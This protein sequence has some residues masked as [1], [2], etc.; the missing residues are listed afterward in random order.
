M[1]L[2]KLLNSNIAITRDDSGSPDSYRYQ[3]TELAAF[4]S[5]LVKSVGQA[6]SE[7]AA[8]AVVAATGSPMTIAA[9]ARQAVHLTGGTV[10]AVALVRNAV[11]LPVAYASAGML[12]PMAPGDSLVLT[13]TVAPTIRTLAQ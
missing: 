4:L 7:P 1:D 13:Y 5:K 3:T 12:I 2:P 8:P 6:Y 10:S 11:S 9:T